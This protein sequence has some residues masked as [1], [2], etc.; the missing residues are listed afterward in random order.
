MTDPYPEPRWAREP[1]TSAPNVIVI[2]AD[3]LGYSDLG[4]FGGEISTPTLD[5]LGRDG[6]RMT[7]F[8]NTA[9][10]SPSRA[11]LLTGQHPHQ[12][13]IG[14]LTDDDRPHGYPGS[15]RSDVPTI[16]ELFK[17][18]GYATALAG[19]WHL[20][21]DVTTPNETW[22]T[23]RGFDDFFGILAGADSYFNPRGLYYNE[24]H[25]EVNDPDFYLTDAIS[26][27]AAEFIAQS[28]AERTPFFLYLA[29]TAP[30][31][32]LH[33]HEADVAPYLETYQEGWDDL[34]RRRLERLI[35][36]GLVPANTTLSQRDPSQPMWDD[37]PDRDWNARRMAT[38]AAQVSNMDSGIATVL[39]ALGGDADNT[40]TMF[41]SDNGASAE[42][43]PPPG[44][45][46]FA[47]RQPTHTRSGEPIE[48]GNTPHITPGG[49]ATYASYGTAWANLSNA[50]FRLYKEWVHEGGIS[51]PLIVSWP[52]VLDDTARIIDEPFQLTDIVP[53]LVEA[54]GLPVDTGPGRSM[55]P[56]WRAETSNED[57]PLFWEH[58]GNSAIR[59]GR[60]KLLRT[61][62][63][64]WALYDLSK[65]RAEEHDR[66]DDH[67]DRV[68]HMAALWQDW[69]DSNGVIPWEKIEPHLAY[70]PTLE[71]A[72]DSALPR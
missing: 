26:D 16:A 28:R 53:T 37:A 59:I 19:K 44:A 15:L 55:L 4:C 65:D 68:A 31:W 47:R 17:A 36:E 5:A 30:H 54:A 46:N 11:S 8:Y 72:L 25:F 3:D 12:T 49:E 60:W 20:S 62:F 63:A 34:R 51:T 32:P 29:Y 22:P 18:S 14:I 61:G 24:E 23:R 48:I 43:M 6:I 21:H 64:D 9:R 7:S 13:G 41:L 56:T 33:A 58:L 27:H 67:P 35:H 66:A 50:P 57:V 40:L 42:T 52:E 2:L 45:T 10:C 71:P 39:N 69:A 38:Y 1:K 70:T